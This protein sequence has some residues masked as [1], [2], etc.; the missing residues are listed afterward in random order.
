MRRLIPL[1]E[2]EYIETIKQTHRI[3]VRLENHTWKLVEAK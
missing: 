2:R 3:L 1:N